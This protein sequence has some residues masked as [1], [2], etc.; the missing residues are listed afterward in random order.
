[1]LLTLTQ[2]TPSEVEQLLID[3]ASVHGASEGE[4]L[5]VAYCENRNFIP[6]LRNSYSGAI[7]IGQWM[8]GRGNHWD[9]TPAWRENRI[10]IHQEYSIGNINSL[11][12]DVDMLAWS[13]G[14]EAQILYPGNKRGWSCY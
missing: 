7:G 14:T 5:R 9:R 3:R 1:M 2:I 11:Y 12:F 4:L 8:P 6:G 10:D 13:F